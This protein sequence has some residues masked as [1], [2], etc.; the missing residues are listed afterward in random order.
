MVPAAT[1][2]LLKTGNF[3]LI[4][5]HRVPDTANPHVFHRHPGTAHA[6]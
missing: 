5:N 1:V 2:N 4:R 3:Q 6:D